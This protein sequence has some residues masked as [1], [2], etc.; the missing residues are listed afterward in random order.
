MESFPNI[1]THITHYK[2]LY[3]QYPNSIFILNIRNKKNWLNSRLNH[4]NGRYLK[5][6]KQYYKLSTEQVIKL[7]SDTWDKHIADVKQF[8]K[9]KPDLLLI[10]NIEKDDFSKLKLFLKKHGYRINSKKLPRV[11]IKKKK[12]IQV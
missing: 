4:G 11:G 9:D 1:Y 12:R 2:K 5:R 3:K 6:F 8:F 10:Y 7:W